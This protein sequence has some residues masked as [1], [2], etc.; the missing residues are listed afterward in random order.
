MA[1]AAAQRR[2]ASRGGSNGIALAAAHRRALA[3]VAACWR[4]MAFGISASAA[5]RE[6]SVR[7]K[8][9]AQ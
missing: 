4:G 7:K 9:R 1:T 6:K 2:L 3:A 8:W 5:W